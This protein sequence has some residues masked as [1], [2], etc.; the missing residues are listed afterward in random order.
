MTG[1]CGAQFFINHNNANTTDPRSYFPSIA[2]QLVDHITN[3]DVTLAIH[4]ALR[5]KRALVDDI[6]TEQAS[7]LFIDAIEFACELYPHKPVVVVFDGLDE[8]A[9]LRLKFTAE[10]QRKSDDRTVCVWDWK[11]NKLLQEP[12]QG[13]TGGVN[14]VSFSPDGKQIVSCSADHRPHCSALGL[15]KWATH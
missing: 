14:S 5:Q 13:H 15:E 4:G 10:I 11:H 6:S 7:K 12:F 8:T 2:R 1:H 3:S 9:R